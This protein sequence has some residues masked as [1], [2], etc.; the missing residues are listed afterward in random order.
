MVVQIYKSVGFY[1][2]MK[3]KQKS[4]GWFGGY[5]SFKQLTKEK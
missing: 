4:G 1:K 2:F 3:A 5:S